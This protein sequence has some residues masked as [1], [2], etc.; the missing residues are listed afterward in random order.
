MIWELVQFGADLVQNLRTKRGVTLLQPLEIIWCRGTEL[1]RPH[2]DF[3][4]KIFYIKI[5]ILCY[6]VSPE[7][8]DTGF[9][10]PS[11]PQASSLSSLSSPSSL[12]KN[13]LL[14]IHE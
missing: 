7:Q 12:R 9:K 2:E 13:M 10:H 6:P 3:Q 5:N 1:N 4:S 8:G 14:D 11:P